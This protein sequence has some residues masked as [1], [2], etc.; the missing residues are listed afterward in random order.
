MDKYGG[1]GD[2]LYIELDGKV[3]EDNTGGVLLTRAS[4]SAEDNDWELGAHFLVLFNRKILKIEIK[5]SANLNQFGWRARPPT[6]AH[7][8]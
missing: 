4:W 8:F 3:G 1:G 6:L 5:F 2:I 7:I